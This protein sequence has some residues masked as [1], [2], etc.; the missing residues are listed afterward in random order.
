MLQ[1]Y[2]WNE[3]RNYYRL[4]QE[5][6]TVV[7]MLTSNSMSQ[8]CILWLTNPFK[9]QVRD[10][11]SEDSDSQECDLPESCNGVETGILGHP[12]MVLHT[13]EGTDDVAVC[14]VSP[15]LLCSTL[16][17]SQ[18]ITKCKLQLTTLHGRD[19]KAR[20]NTY[21]HQYDHEFYL[22]IRPTEP[23]RP[24]LYPQ[25]RLVN[26]IWLRKP[27][28]LSI[29]KRYTVPLS[30]LEPYDRNRSESHYRLTPGSF[31]I[32]ASTFAMKIAMPAEMPAIKTARPV[33]CKL[34]N[35]TQAQLES[36]APTPHIESKLGT[37]KSSL[38]KSESSAKLDNE[39]ERPTVPIPPVIAKP[40]SS[41]TEP[42]GTTTAT[43][44]R[45]S[46]MSGGFRNLVSAAFAI[47]AYKTMRGYGDAWKARYTKIKDKLCSVVFDTVK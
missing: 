28:Y 33:H 4:T 11:G 5:S 42:L 43:S 23:P 26:D 9:D 25:L 44:K 22:A 6:F 15:A 47:D 13:L 12:V 38:A 31:A 34:P 19:L 37:E 24:F 3:P 7:I 1:P 20:K 2:D 8:G 18:L 41:D 36:E 10:L 39:L 40:S 30:M 35:A 32:V 17:C 29:K 45:R 46:L 21:G 14:L 16:S 27:G